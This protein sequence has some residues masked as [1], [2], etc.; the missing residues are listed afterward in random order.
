MANRFWLMWGWKDPENR[1]AP[2]LVVKRQ[3]TFSTTNYNLLLDPDPEEASK[4]R[5][6]ELGQLVA[7]LGGSLPYG[8]G[9]LLEEGRFAPLC[10]K[11]RNDF[12][13]P[14]H[15]FVRPWPRGWTREVPFP[16][17]VR[18][19]MQTQ[20]GPCFILA[21]LAGMTETRWERRFYELYSAHAFDLARGR[22]Y[23]VLQTAM[24]D[25]SAGGLP[26]DVGSDDWTQSLWR[27]LIATLTLPALLPQTILNLER[28]ADIPSDHPDLNFFE[29][30]VGSVGFAF[31]HH[32]KRHIVEIDRAAR[33]GPGAGSVRDLRIDR[34]LGQQGWHVHRFGNREVSKAKNF[35]E[36]AWELG[37]PSRLYTRPQDPSDVV[38]DDGLEA[39][40][41]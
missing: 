12:S 35:E 37:F 27:R 17:G 19:L 29:R 26:A 9:R 32:G 39:V 16:D 28:T 40:D 36:F 6:F 2:R 33:R 11:C 14:C 20:P 13:S 34:G 15:L 30:N 21:R 5:D 10:G 7:A 31:V 8:P 22:A 25:P 18:S 24:A 4:P 41:P 23:E 1:P 3:G 38:H